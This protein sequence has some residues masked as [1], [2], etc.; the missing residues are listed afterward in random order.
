[1][2]KTPSYH[3]YKINFIINC[4]GEAFREKYELQNQQYIPRMLRPGFRARYNSDVLEIDLSDFPP[5][6][7][8]NPR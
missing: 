5:H 2:P 6:I 1:M 4:R 8:V 3:D 7:L